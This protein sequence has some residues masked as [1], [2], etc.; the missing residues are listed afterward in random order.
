MKVTLVAFDQ[1]TDVDLFLP[2]DL[3]NR[4][5][6]KRPDWS[7][8]IVGTQ[9][10]HTSV[11]GLTVPVHGLIEECNDADIVFF[12]SGAGSR[13][14]ITDREYLARYQ[15]NP[16][17]QLIGS[18]CSGALLLAAL[19]LLTNKTA[20]TYPSA[21]P[22]LESFGVTVVDEP[23]VVHG[24]VATAAGCLAALDLVGWML[25]Q[26]DGPAL[27]EAVLASVQPA[28]KQLACIY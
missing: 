5:L 23:L 2:W 21:R 14:L 11:T 10:T 18:M 15:L 26:A 3:F 13:K 20:T 7:V 12:G 28:G 22:A 8:R 16:D 19:G 27:R 25:E 6:L 9:P 17:R 24:N 1:F 4:V